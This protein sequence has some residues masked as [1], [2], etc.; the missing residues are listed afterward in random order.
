VP[1]SA[2]LPRSTAHRPPTPRVALTGIAATTAY[3]LVKTHGNLHAALASLDKEKHPAPAD[4]NYA[5]VRA[6]FTEPEV[7]DAAALE[8]KWTDPDE[9]GIMDFL[10]KEKVSCRAGL[11]V[12]VSMASS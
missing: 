11:R 7:A 5:E 12:D 6:L 4:C 1:V 8:L 10:V 2:Q 9:A 3:R